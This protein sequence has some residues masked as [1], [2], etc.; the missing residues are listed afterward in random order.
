[1]FTRRVFQRNVR[2]SR[3]SQD[4]II[5]CNYITLHLHTPTMCIECVCW[6]ELYVWFSFS[7]FNIVVSRFNIFFKGVW[8]FVHANRRNIWF[9]QT[10]QKTNNYTFI[11]LELLQ[12]Y[13]RHIW[14]PCWSKNKYKKKSKRLNASCAI[15][16]LK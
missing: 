16:K 12:K 13:Y 8:H 14:N 11:I 3:Y 9:P 15:S 2:R 7:L 1:M 10:N 5:D 6:S 4:V